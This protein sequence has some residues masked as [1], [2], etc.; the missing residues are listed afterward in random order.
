[1]LPKP[2][3]QDNQLCITRS[4][5]TCQANE[6]PVRLIKPTLLLT[7]SIQTFLDTTHC[8]TLLPQCPIHLVKDKQQFPKAFRKCNITSLHK[9]KAKNNFETTGEFSELES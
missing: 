3:T 8:I 6:A 5:G 7:S 2:R 1:M 9:K 4:L